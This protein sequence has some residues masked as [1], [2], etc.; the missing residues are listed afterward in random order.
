MQPVK[1]TIRGRFWDSQLYKG[2]LYLFDLNGSLRGID[3]N[4]LVQSFRVPDRCRLALECAFL[5]SD[6]LY[7]NKWDK[8]YGDR[9]ISTLLSSKF[10]ELL[11]Q[12]LTIDTP[13]LDHLTETQANT[14]FPYAHNDSLIYRDQLYATSQSGVF[15]RSVSEFRNWSSQAVKLWDAPVSGMD[16]SYDVLALAAGDE[17]LYRALTVTR[18]D[19][20]KNKQDGPK[21]VSRD[22]CND[23][24]YISSS[25]LTF[26]YDSG[27]SLVEFKSPNRQSQKTEDAV[28][29][30]FWQ[31]IPVGIVEGEEIFGE[32]TLGGFVW[33]SKNRMCMAK[34]GKLHVA[35][36]KSTNP[37]R[38]SVAK[39]VRTIQLAQWKGSPVSGNNAVFGAILEMDNCLV[40]VRSDNNVETLRGEPTNWRVFP[41]SRFYT[42]QLHAIYDDR[43]EILSYNHDYFVNQKDKAFGEPQAEHWSPQRMPQ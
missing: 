19:P 36:Y 13:Q 3:W 16:V 42:N 20:W 31:S 35:Q 41:R 6:Y 37:R 25:I 38:T 34:D 5:R 40:V 29:E 32:S 10:D 26:G 2:R 9:E 27:A 18:F 30:E 24:N 12:E 22:L 1:L 14:P 33:G 11:Q 43:V 4:A 28:F 39:E 23:C 8:F 17:G 21:R 15:A 7:G